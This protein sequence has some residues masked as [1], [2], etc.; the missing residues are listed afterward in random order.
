MFPTN[1]ITAVFVIFNAIIII[2]LLYIIY[3]MKFIHY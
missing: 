1:A 2:I 3:Q